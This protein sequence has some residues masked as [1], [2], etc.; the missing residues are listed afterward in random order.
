V[1]EI[2]H[3]IIDQKYSHRSIVVE[4]LVLSVSHLRFSLNTS[5]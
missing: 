1:G 3:T 5:V 4:K 2:S